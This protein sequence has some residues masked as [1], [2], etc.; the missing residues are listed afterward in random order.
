MAWVLEHYHPFNTPRYTHKTSLDDFDKIEHCLVTIQRCLPIITKFCLLPHYPAQY[1]EDFNR[2]LAMV[3]INVFTIANICHVDSQ[4]LSAPCSPML[5]SPLTKSQLFLNTLDSLSTIS[6][7]CSSQTMDSSMQKQV[8][9]LF[10][11]ILCLETKVSMPF[12]QF[13]NFLPKVIVT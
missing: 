13:L 2:A 3:T 10:A 8:A 1:K 12:D 9:L 5:R 11:C 4:T 7:L 6:S